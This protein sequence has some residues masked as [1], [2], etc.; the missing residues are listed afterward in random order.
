MIAQRGSPQ[1]LYEFPSSEFVAGFM[2]EAMLFPAKADA[3]GTV[4][5]GPLRI[6]PRQGMS[7]GARWTIPSANTGSANVAPIQKRRVISRSS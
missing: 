7:E 5:L 3:Q 2:G 4:A 1:E 6:R